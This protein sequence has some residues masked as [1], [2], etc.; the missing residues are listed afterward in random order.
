MPI[1]RNILRV[2]GGSAKAAALFDFIADRTLG[3]GSVDFNRI[4][5]MPPWVFREATNRDLLKKYGEENCSRGWCMKHWGCAQNVLHPEE[6]QRLYD[7]GDTLRFDTEDNDVWELIQ[8][9]SLIFKDVYLDYL[10][11]SE[12]VGSNVGAMQFKDGEILI[13]FIPASGSR[14]A[15]EKSL[16]ILGARATDF[17]LV[18]DANSGNYEYRGSDRLGKA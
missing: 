5:P 18:Y 13:E 16:D 12:D 17:G 11:A 1:I 15:V 14:V 7:N 9:L 2:Q 10:W 6:T 4:A 3:R 8:K